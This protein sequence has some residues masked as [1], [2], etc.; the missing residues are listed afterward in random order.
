MASKTANGAGTVYK[1]KDGRFE[2]AAYVLA[3]GGKRVRARVYADTQIE[4]RRKL[5]QVIEHSRQGIPL[6]DG[7]QSIAQ[8]MEHWLEVVAR[9]RIRPLTVHSYESLIRLHIIPKL[10]TKKL[11]TLSVA[12][13]QGAINQMLQEGTSPR[14]VEKFRGVLR[15]ALNSAMR[16]ELI[17]RNVAKLVQL[18]RV[19]RKPIE[20]WSL[21]E[22][23]AFVAAARDH[24]WYPAFMLLLGYGLRKGEA[25]GLRWDDVDFVNKV[26]HIRQQIQYIDGVVMATDVK[27][28]AGRRTLPLVRHAHDVLTAEAARQ[29]IDISRAPEPPAG[30]STEN[31]ITTSALGTPVDPA[32][33]LRTFQ[34][35]LK[36][37]GVRR[38]T[39][40]QMRHTVATMLA[41][42]GTQE[43]DA[44]LILGHAHVTT[45]Q[46]IYQ[47]GSIAQRGAAL[48]QVSE[49][50]DDDDT[51]G[52]GASSDDAD[53]SGCRQKLPSNGP[54]AIESSESQDPRQQSPTGVKNM[55]SD[56]TPGWDRTS[57]MRLRSKSQRFLALI[58]TPVIQTEIGRTRVHMVA[59]VAVRTAV[60]TDRS[61]DP[62]LPSVDELIDAR[63][64]LS[65]ALTER[66]RQLSFPLNLIPNNPPQGVSP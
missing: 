12:D 10:G 13:V 36:K 32:N 60:K 24:R 64:A 5:S 27:T 55:I 26:I 42:T 20:P 16:Q 15:A 6:A 3:V 57:D 62:S 47:H 14:T 9:P 25:L 51:D 61:P 31:L 18:P 63:A 22:A 48:E 11:A 54:F 45:T 50:F 23:R 37:A 38:I 46:M 53:G 44:Q 58:P 17:F 34:I 41:A 29:G 2:G 28:E 56:G 1:R 49:V 40:H 65:E 39:I 19:S 43:R 33:F 21:D 52:S 66:L 7:T 30:L 59:R 8:Y 35:V 4:A